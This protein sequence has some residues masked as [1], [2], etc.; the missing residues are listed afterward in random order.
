MVDYWKIKAQLLQLKVEEQQLQAMINDVWQR[1]DIFCKEH[2]LPL[3]NLR[4]DDEKL[5][6]EE[7]KNNVE[8]ATGR[9]PEGNQS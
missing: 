8:Q 5:C 7:I 4:F 2:N 1:R 3:G 9:N 6:I